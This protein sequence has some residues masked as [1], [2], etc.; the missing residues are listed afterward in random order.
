MSPSPERDAERPTPSTDRSAPRWAKLFGLGVVA[1]LAV[2]L[3]IHLLGGGMHH[4]LPSGA[5]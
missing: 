2:F 3:V 4:H 5:H 1:L